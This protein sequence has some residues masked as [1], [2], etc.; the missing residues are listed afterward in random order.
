M[1]WFQSVRF[2]LMGL[3]ALL[4]IVALAVVSGGGYYF[5]EKYLGESLD[6]TERSV[7]ETAIT[8]IQGEM[9]TGMI[10]LEELANNDRV[11]SG[12]KAQILPALSSLFQR[13]GRFDHVFYAAMDG[14]SVSDE[15]VA[16]QY[17][18]REYFKRVVETK[19]PYI[20]NPLI[21]RTTGKQSVVMIVPVL[22]PGTSEMTGVVFGTYSAE[23]LLPVVKIIK[24]KTKGY[25]AL[26]ADNGVYLV[27]PTRPDLNGKMNLKTGAIDEEVK[28]KLPPNAA[29]D[30]QLLGGFKKVT[31]TGERLRF[32]YKA[33]NGAEQIGSLNIISLPGGQRW[34]LL[35]TTSQEDAAS[36]TSALTKILLGLA[37]GCL[38]I[39]LLIAYWASGSFVRPILRIMEV[40]KDIA[41][42]NLRE[43]SK[44]IDD[45]SEFGQLSD[46]VLLMNRNLR[47]LVQ[48]VQ[49]QSHQLA[50]SSEQLTAGAQQ[51]ADAANQ[52]A[53]SITEMAKG[54]EDQVAAVN[55]TAAIVEEI[56]ATIE[57]VVLTA[58]EMAA[59][60]EKAVAATSDG[61]QAVDRAVTQMG[62][63][64][65]GARKAHAAAGDLE[66]GSRQIEEIVGLIS[67]IAGQTNLLA[68]NAAIEAAR[69][70]EQGKGF[71]V[72]A[73]EVRKLAEQS[74]NAAQQIKGIIGINNANIRNVVE[75]IGEASAN[76]EQGVG[77]VNSAGEGFAAI[78]QQVHDVAGRVGGLSTAFTEVG[79]GSK[80]IVES[81]RRVEKISREAALEAQ[82]ISAATEE[83][84]ASTEEIASSSQSLAKLAGD[85]QEAVAKFQV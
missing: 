39:A 18:D 49:N 57:D 79:S 40:A 45:K 29:L 33:T 61:Q 28:K 20:S 9:Q 85:L 51:S 30:P 58:R 26:L 66:S 52:V 1:A 10:Q 41:A 83:Q 35:L 70:G 12:D 63:V 55:E 4:I 62:S 44:T 65:E 80:R 69:A 67:N 42:G 14:T 16:G 31:E 48:Q 3:I 84:S 78:G 60:A 74:E 21:S 64:G 73:E 34:V 75:A 15:G 56:S 2:R 38:A 77:L 23:K 43:I 72:V 5:S 11:Q 50:A 82:S 27:H 22:K 32:P 59:M 68:L 8:R 36:E 6:Q 53:G 81:M 25:G 47:S 71:A 37:L 76:I 19:K 54:A 17:A 13:S 46:S 24:Y 7:A